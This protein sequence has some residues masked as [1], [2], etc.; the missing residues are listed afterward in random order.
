M[1]IS[2]AA[3]AANIRDR[4]WYLD[5][6]EASKM[7]QVSTGKGITVAVI[8]SG[9]NASAPELRGRVLPG[10][11]F[12][13]DGGD[14]QQDP[15]G[16]GTDMA[17]LIAGDGNSGSGVM[18]LAP[19]ARILPLRNGGELNAAQHISDAIRYAAD[20]GAK[21][22]NISEGVLGSGSTSQDGMLFEPAVKYAL[23]H[24]SLIFTASG[25][26]GDKGNAI[27]YPAATPGAVA[28]AALDESGNVAKFSTYGP[29][30]A[31]AA[32]GKNIPGQCSKSHG[33]AGGYC[34]GD[35]TSQ[36]TAIASA[37]AA[38]IWAKHP[39][40]TNNQVLRVMLNT[41]GKPK[42]GKV[43]SIYIGYGSVRPRVTLLGN[44]GD[45]GPA[46]VNP[47]F[48]KLFSNSPS[49]S[50]STSVLPAPADHPSAAKSS[51]GSG[52]LWVG[53]GIGGVVALG[54]LT[55]VAV[56]RRRKAA[57]GLPAVPP[58]VPVPPQFG[59]YPGS[60][61][62]SPSNPPAAAPRFPDGNRPPNPYQR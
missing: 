17:A 43:P 18:G 29:Q 6:M 19:D 14:A 40:W 37:S 38:L 34:M 61:S 59:P 52:T 2:P 12:G 9:V 13:A 55:T 22:I 44:P 23:S 21:I 33:K 49:A 36:A 45:P 57:Q 53:L 46:N 10:R 60:G 39:D 3:Q 5:A 30:V 20:H 51:G 8:D 58:V 25:N 56:I 35:G 41:A 15:D 16:H 26:E 4:E 11:D 42:T 27:D 7:W 32:P 48:P 24:G 1:A 50:A 28:V 47:L 62:P 54:A 31:L